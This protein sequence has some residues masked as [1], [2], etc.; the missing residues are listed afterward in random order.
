MVVEGKTM[1][2]DKVTNKVCWPYVNDLLDLYESEYQKYIETKC[3][4]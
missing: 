4:K 1:E 2:K 3:T